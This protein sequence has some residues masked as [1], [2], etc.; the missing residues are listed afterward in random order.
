MDYLIIGAGG[1]GGCLAAF[2]A[3]AGKRVHVIARGDHL[4]AIQRNG[5][6]LET[7]HGSFA[8][9][10]CASTAEDYRG[11]PDVIFL[12]VKDYGVEALLPFLAEICDE[13]TILIPLL[14]IYGTGAWLQARLPR[15]LV[16][17]GC[18]YIA[19]EITSPGTLRMR[20][21]ILRVVFGVR[22]GQNQPPALTQV[23]QDLAAAGIDARLSPDIATDAMVKF[24]FVSPMAACGLLHSA[25]AGEMQHPGPVSSDFTA[26]VE[27]VSAVAQAM[28]LHLPGNLADRNLQILDGLDPGASTSLKRDL[29]A[30]RPSELE[31]LIFQVVRLGRRHL[32]STPRYLAAAQAFGFQ[33]VTG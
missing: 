14:N 15:P 25:L 33:E 28:G 24:S 22:G 29:D 17:D 26:L 1:T 8:I 4:R 5:I 10:V 30:G 20:G 6:V 11:R 32:V 19:G 31:G 27:E 13:R 7:S 12:C 9:P 21:D 23:A 2:L 16:T 18:I 3:Q